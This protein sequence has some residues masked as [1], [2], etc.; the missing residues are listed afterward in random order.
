MPKRI[1]IDGSRLT[2][3]E[4]VDVA[5]RATPVSL[6]APARRAVMRSHAFLERL[7]ERGESVYGVTTGT[8]DLASVAISR[9]L[10]AELQ[11][12][13][14]LS[15]AAGFGEPQPD[16]VVRA[17]MLCRA[18]TLA[19]GRSGVR[20]DLVR[21]LLDLL[22]AGVTPIVCEKGSVGAS[23]DLSPLCQV[24][25]VI[26]GGGEVRYRGERMPAALALKKARIEPL[27]LH[28]KEGIGLI[29]G[30][31]MMTGEAALHCFD[32]ENVV[33]N[34]V[35]AA[36]MTLEALRGALQAFDARIHEARPFPGQRAVASGIRRLVA[37]SRI[38]AG[39]TGRVQDAYSL[40]CI[41]Q[42]LGPTLDALAYASRQ[43]GIEM[44]SA[45]DN[46][47]FFS[48]D[49]E[50]L[51]GGNFHGQPVAMAADFLGIALCEAASLGERHVN[52]MLNASLSGLPPYL[53]KG[54][55]LNS[56]LMGAQL[57]AAAL[58]SENKVLA[59]PGVVD[60]ISVSSD[61]EDHVSMGPVSVRTLKEIR[62]NTA[63]V[64]A[65]EMLCAAQ[66]IDFRGAR[67]TGAGVRAA[68]RVV[69]GAVTHL[70]DDRP[71][72]PDI[73]KVV[74]LVESGAVVGAVERKIGSLDLGTRAD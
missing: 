51:A 45:A 14:V 65:I 46:P 55:G 69:R 30:S 28:F 7:V 29:N 22:N 32:A 53:A 68:H 61:E 20:L 19:K 64:I 40:R 39:P 12:R 54:T 52:R 59:H 4:L 42:I 49:R 47:L 56:G 13:I 62:C 43:I 11:R 18:N 1:A 26:M 21:M 23:G 9:E 41:P 72:Y 37:G 15:H 5:R 31:Q 60:S 3:R 38:L 74:D 50:H 27:T 34:A 70:V 73:R 44:N 6:S 16:A 36:A 24:A 67:K 48:E 2:I 33:K 8:G 25:E 58:V 35:I 57:T 71:L 63:A 10:G 66:A 17:G